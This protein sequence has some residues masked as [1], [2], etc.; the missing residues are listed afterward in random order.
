M[1]PAQ[2]H[3]ATGRGGA[4]AGDALQRR[5]TKRCSK[6]STD[7]LEGVRLA[8]RF[9]QPAHDPSREIH[10]SKCCVLPTGPSTRHRRHS[11]GRWAAAATSDEKCEG[12]HTPVLFLVVCGAAAK[13]TPSDGS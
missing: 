2:R 3:E 9:A 11:P 12:R 5:P 7:A 8:G 13:R 1:Q 10:C 4:I 6:C